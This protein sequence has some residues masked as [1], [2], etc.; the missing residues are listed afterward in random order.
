MNLAKHFKTWT[1]DPLIQAQMIEKTQVEGPLRRLLALMLRETG[2]NGATQLNG[3][4]PK[5]TSRNAGR[6]GKQETETDYGSKR[7]FS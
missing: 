6:A 3:N 1:T 2:S 5:K 7:I 4:V